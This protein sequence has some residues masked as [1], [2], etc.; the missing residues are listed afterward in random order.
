MINPN[1]YYTVQAWMVNDLG[2]KDKELIVYAII[3]GFSQDGNSAYSGS[4]RYLAEWVGCARSTIMKVLKSLTEKKLLIK[5]DINQNGV[6]FCTYRAVICCPK[7]VQ[8]VQKSDTPCI[9]NGQGGVQK[10]DTP[11]TEIGHNNDRDN[12]LDNYR[13]KDMD[14]SGASP[15][16]DGEAEKGKSVK[17]KHGEYQNVLLTDEEMD[18]LRQIFPADLETRIE[19]LSEYIASTGKKYKSHYA[20]IRA[21]ANRDRKPHQPA[22]SPGRGGYRGNIGPNGIPIDPTK[23]DLDGLI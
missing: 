5:K 7:T 16:P 15:L 4:A 20:T 13:D 9:E 12:N 2:L 3:Y 11:C 23:N 8:G 22:H 14:E 1:T 10:S 18:K 21:W 19:R 6:I 17:H